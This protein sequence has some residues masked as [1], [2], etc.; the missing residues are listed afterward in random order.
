MNISEIQKA[1]ESGRI[2]WRQHA[3]KRMLERDIAR[4]DIANV[5]KHGE[6]V[7][8]Y[9]SSQPYPS[10]LILGLPRD[11][12]FHVVAAYD[13][14][15]HRVYVLTA[16]QPDTIHFLADLKTRRGVGHEE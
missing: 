14:E 10:C 13:E 9:P 12:T 7:E 8:D 2:F 6:M 11:I 4:A 3:L 15:D 16:Y 1:F 5:I